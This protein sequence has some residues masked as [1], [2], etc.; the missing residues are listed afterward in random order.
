MRHAEPL[1]AVRTNEME[2][3]TGQEASAPSMKEMN[4]LIEEKVV[5]RTLSESKLKDGAPALSLYG[6]HTHNYINPSGKFIIGVLRAML[7]SPAAREGHR[8]DANSD[9]LVKTDEPIEFKMAGQADGALVPVNQ[10]N[11]YP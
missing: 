3:Y 10:S 2:G 1:K 11:H 6:A 5:R 7:V 8:V 4:K 9:G